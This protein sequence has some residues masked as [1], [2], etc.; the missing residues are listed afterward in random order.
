MLSTHLRSKWGFENEVKAAVPSDKARVFGILM[1]ESFRD[2]LHILL[3]K[4]TPSSEISGSRRHESDDP[5]FRS[6]NIWTR[7]K[8]CF[9]DVKFIVRHPNNWDSVLGQLQSS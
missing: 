3:G 5:S 8:T 9:H 6:R 4:K 2:E 1:D 7:V